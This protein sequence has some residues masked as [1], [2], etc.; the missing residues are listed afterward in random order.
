MRI[1]IPQYAKNLARRAL[2]ERS[3]LK[4]SKRFGLDKIQANKLNINS[5]VERA[6]QI[7]RSKYIEGEDAKAVA[8]FIRF[9]NAKTNKEVGALNLWGGKRFV[10]KVYNEVYKK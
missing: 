2:K 1:K 4:P 6:K 3:R 5:G 7:V 10:T 8:R 9:K